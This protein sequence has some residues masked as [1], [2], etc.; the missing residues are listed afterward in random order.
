MTI[1]DRILE[2]IHEKGM[3]QKEFS[4]ITG[5]P[6][7]TISS[8]KGKKQNPGMDKLQV[9]CDVLK[10]DPYFLISGSKINETVNMDYIIVYRKDQK[11]YELL[12]DYRKMGADSKNRLLGY[13][14]ALAES[15]AECKRINKESSKSAG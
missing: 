4:E 12:I 5:I 7:S 8:W 15:E 14:K 1:G 2:L 6:Q 11:E 13:A 10:V 3:T 9:I